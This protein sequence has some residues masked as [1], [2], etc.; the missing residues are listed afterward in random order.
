MHWTTFPINVVIKIG[1][2]L[3]KGGCPDIDTSTCQYCIL[4]YSLEFSLGHKVF[5]Y[6]RSYL[7]YGKL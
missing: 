6:E 5:H 3:L 1:H 4:L 2:Y 7:N